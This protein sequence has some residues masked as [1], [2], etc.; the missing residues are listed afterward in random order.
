MGNF[1]DVDA[2]KSRQ[3]PAAY[4]PLKRKWFEEIK[5]GTKTEEYREKT[6][7]RAAQ[8]AK[9]VPGDVIEFS[10]GYPKKDDKERRIQKRFLSVESRTIE[11]EEF[12]G[13]SLEVFAILFENIPETAGRAEFS[14]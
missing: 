13:E 5:A 2:I 6:Q 4:F 1:L 7:R 11:H 3:R 8:L 14:I 10:L 9:L 12:G